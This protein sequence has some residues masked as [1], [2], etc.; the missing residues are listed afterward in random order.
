[1]IRRVKAGILYSLNDPGG[2]DPWALGD[3][4]EIGKIVIRSYEFEFTKMK[5]AKLDDQIAFSLDS[6]FTQLPI[7]L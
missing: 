4:E 1:M 6:V 3:I 7:Q 5:K 2:N